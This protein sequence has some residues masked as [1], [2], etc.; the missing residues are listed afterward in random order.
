MTAPPRRPSGRPTGT[1]TAPIGDA[2]PKHPEPDTNPHR[3][4]AG[5]DA[6]VR[7]LGRGFMVAF[8]G[9]MRAIKLY[10]LENAAVVK[11][12]DDL[13]TATRALIAEEEELEFRTSG[14]FIF[15]NST[16][17][18]LDLDNYASFSHLLTLFRSG[19]I[20]S[21]RVAESVTPRD[22]LV[23]LSL[24][25]APGEGEPEDRF[26]QLNGKLALANVTTLELGPPATA[27]PKSAIASSRRKRPSGRTRSPSPCRRKSCTPFAWGGRPTSRSSSASCRPSWT[28]SST[29]KHRSLG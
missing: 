4:E 11:A 20:G 21:L 17:L 7:R 22:W 5:S 12:L 13:T 3:N 25:Q 1:I 27:V 16:R 8:Y 29:T 18:R 24:V 9:A 19:G 26:E 10:P 23:F 14:E 6:L 28:R 2:P 15:I